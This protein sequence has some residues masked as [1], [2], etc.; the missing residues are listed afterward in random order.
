MNS[1]GC[2][3]FGNNPNRHESTR[4]FAVVARVS[5]A[6]ELAAGTAALQRERSD[7]TNQGARELDWK[8]LSVFFAYLIVSA[9]DG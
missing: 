8:H 2:F 9:K 7:P 5:R 1:A 4:G 3:C 6:G